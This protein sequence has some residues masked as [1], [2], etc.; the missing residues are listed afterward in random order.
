MEMKVVNRSRYLVVKTRAKRIWLFPEIPVAN[1][2]RRETLSTQT[3]R[4]IHS[5]APEP[6]L[7]KPK[8]HPITLNNA[9]LSRDC[10]PPRVRKHPFP[11]DPWS[12]FL[13]LDCTL[14][15]SLQ[16]KTRTPSSQDRCACLLWGGRGGGGSQA[17]GRVSRLFFA[18]P[19]EFHWQSPKLHLLENNSLIPQGVDSSESGTDGGRHRAKGAFYLI[20][21]KFKD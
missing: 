13:S 18:P 21:P 1:G 7:E 12:L 20:F 4:L 19:P 16:I 11:L 2:D 3:P 5:W 17:G 14:S 8:E 9:T 6:E 10:H 15:P